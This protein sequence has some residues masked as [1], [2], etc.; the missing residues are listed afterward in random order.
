MKEKQKVIVFGG[1]GFIGSHVADFLSKSGYD[2]TV[3]DI[4]PS[5]YLKSDQ[6]MMVGDIS[7]LD[8]VKEVV[9]NS[10]IVY[11]FAGI[12][13]IDEAKKSPL[14]TIKNDILGN[15]NILES[16]KDRSVKRYV[17][18]STLY[19]YSNTGTF[20]KDSKT[21]CELY[22]NDYSKIYGIPYTILR[23]GSI[24]GPRTNQKDRIYILVKQA[25]TEGKMTYCGDGEEIREY[26]HVEDAARCSVE[27]LDEEFINQNVII[28]G[29]QN[30]KIKDLMVMIKEILSG[31]IDIEFLGKNSDLH[32]QITPYSFT[33][34]LGKKYISKQYI[35]LGQ[36]IIQCAEDT[37]N[38][39]SMEYSK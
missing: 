9:I 8:R 37:L 26:I 11:N 27:I 6:K 4:K 34:K 36:G 19:V 16:L 22:I 30:F 13:D 24:Y 18:A 7:D 15:A 28:T 12:S 25:L 2:V 5:K 31:D 38:S 14:E 35:D 1:S 20:Y 3:F 23:Y 29:H 39:I 17:F 10:D 21:A 32:Y 33:P